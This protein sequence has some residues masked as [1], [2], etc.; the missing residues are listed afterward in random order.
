MPARC[1][2]ARRLKKWSLPGSNMNTNWL[3]A[4]ETLRANYG[5]EFGLQVHYRQYRALHLLS[6]YDNLCHQ[7]EPA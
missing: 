6:Y 3:F 5:A 4:M 1:R 7:G 2:T